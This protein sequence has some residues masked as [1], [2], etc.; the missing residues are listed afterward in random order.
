MAFEGFQQEL[1]SAAMWGYALLASV[2][3]KLFFIRAR[4]YKKRGFM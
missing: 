2:I 1:M 4:S 3:R